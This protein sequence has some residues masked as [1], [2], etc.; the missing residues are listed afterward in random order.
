MANI[1]FLDGTWS[2]A[3][4]VVAYTPINAEAPASNLLLPQP[5]IVYDTKTLI[6]SDPYQ[7]IIEMQGPDTGYDG[8][9]MGYWNVDI[10]G[11]WRT[12][13]ANTQPALVAAPILD[14]GDIPFQKVQNLAD[15]YTRFHSWHIFPTRRFEPW[16]RIVIR[17]PF[18][19][20]GRLMGGVIRIGKIFRPQRNVSFGY[21]FRHVDPSEFSRTYGSTL[22]TSERPGYDEMALPFNFATGADAINFYRL[23]RR[24]GK[25]HAF[26]IYLNSDAITYSLTQIYGKMEMDEPIVRPDLNI[27]RLNVTMHEM[28]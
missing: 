14:T 25:K 4:S 23:Y 7:T 5:S 21:G 13:L 18:N 27:Y 22:H 16:V 11:V 9:F 26:W 8:I 1:L 6:T 19:V 2:E 12:R 15:I 28:T 24:H 3:A 17:N 20:D 10:E